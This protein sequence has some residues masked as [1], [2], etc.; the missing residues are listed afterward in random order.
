MSKVKVF[1]LAKRYGYKSADFVEVMRKIGFP[2]SSY[3]ASVEEWDVPIIEERLRK[4]GLLQDGEGGGEEKK[5]KDAAGGASS[6]DAL[7]KQAQ[8]TESAPAEEAEESQD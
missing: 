4:G 3:Q 2:V 6:W 8:K 7:V 1:T 5:A